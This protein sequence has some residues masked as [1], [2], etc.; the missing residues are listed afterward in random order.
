VG[1][2][3]NHEKRFHA[4]DV[5]EHGIDACPADS[6]PGLPS[7]KSFAS[8]LLRK[9]AEFPGEAKSEK[10]W[11]LTAGQKCYLIVII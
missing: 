5:T 7:G 11:G 6:I 2:H 4:L 9:V 8:L 1:L 10:Y 3:A